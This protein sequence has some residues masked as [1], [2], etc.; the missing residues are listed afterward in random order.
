MNYTSFTLIPLASGQAL[1]G[2]VGKCRLQLTNG[3]AEY[4]FDGV[5]FFTLPSP[6]PWGD[7][8]EVRFPTD[9]YVRNAHGVNT[10]TVHVLTWY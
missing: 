6:P 4:S 2:F 7:V 9:L 1:S 8:L 10:A 3:T 5:T